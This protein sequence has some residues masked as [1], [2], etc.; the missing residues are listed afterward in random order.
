MLELLKLFVSLLI[1]HWV[2]DF[3]LQTDSQAKGK[4]T[5]LKCLLSHTSVYSIAWFYSILLL[6]PEHRPM[7]ALSFAAITFLCHTL[8][9][10]FTSKIVRYFFTK[11]DTHNG[12]VVIGFDQILHYVQLFLTYYYI[13]ETV[14]FHRVLW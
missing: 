12:F 13:Y 9:D 8:T 6:D 4:S 10:F 2:S 1:I 14:Q 5:S 3:I 11:G 7:L